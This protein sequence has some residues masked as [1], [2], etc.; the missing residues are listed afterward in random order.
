M[1]GKQHSPGIASPAAAR[2][3]TSTPSGLLAAR[4]EAPKV[5]LLRGG[6][7]V[8]PMLDQINDHSGMGPRRSVAECAR[9]IFRDLAQDAAH[10]LARAG[11]RQARR[12]LKKI[13]GG[14]RTDVLPPPPP[15]LLAQL[16]AGLG[17]GHQR[18][19]GIDA[20]ALD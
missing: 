17:A 18:D 7:P 1:A 2:G 8:S 10:D 3:P 14:D 13:S 16:L 5:A 15:Q 19:I 20:L 6:L 4:G 12:K 9:L 11:F